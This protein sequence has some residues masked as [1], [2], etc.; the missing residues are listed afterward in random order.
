M[1]F[2]GSVEGCKM[3]LRSSREPIGV[4]VSSRRPRRQS[5]DLLSWRFWINSKEIIVERSINIDPSEG[6]YLI[7]SEWKANDLE[8]SSSTYF[9]AC[10]PTLVSRLSSIGSMTAPYSSKAT[11]RE[12]IASEEN[13]DWFNLILE[14]QL[15][16]IFVPG[17]LR[18]VPSVNRGD[19]E[20]W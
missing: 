20:V 17:L 8:S 2:S 9:R 4:K 13:I 1:S 5:L 7:R 6:S 12:I 11:S 15:L 19:P 16:H 14:S 3:L 18:P 10:L